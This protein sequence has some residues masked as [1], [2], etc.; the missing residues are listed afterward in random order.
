MSFT[1]SLHRE[2]QGGGGGRGRK[3]R[4]KEQMS[5]R[6]KATSRIKRKKKKLFSGFLSIDQTRM[7]DSVEISH[8]FYLCSSFIKEKRSESNNFPASMIPMSC[9][10]MLL[11]SYMGKKKKKK[12]KQTVFVLFSCFMMMPISVS[13]N[14][15]RRPQA[16]YS[17]TTTVTGL[18]SLDPRPHCFIFL[19]SLTK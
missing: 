14:S 18:F 16:V 10:I 15:G 4:R 8:H 7:N 9:Y 11:V 17:Y 5:K 2:E 6:R 1:C 13:L 3:E 12:M 19:M